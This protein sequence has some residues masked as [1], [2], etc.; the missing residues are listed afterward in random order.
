MFFS[1][2]TLLK[3][4]CVNLI[5]SSLACAQILFMTYFFLA[6]QAKSEEEVNSQKEWLDAEKVW[7]VH[8]AGFSGGRVQKTKVAKEDDETLM[9]KV[10]LDH[11]GEIITIEEDSVEKV[12][13]WTFL[14]DG[15]IPTGQS[16]C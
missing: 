8:K 2:T 7:V 15:F 6:L 3:C 5:L 16:K 13:Y 14:Y 1:K 4:M 10:K 12:C 9:C 11:G